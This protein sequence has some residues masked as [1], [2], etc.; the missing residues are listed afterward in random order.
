MAETHPES[1]SMKP[2]LNQSKN[3]RES[4]R[5]GSVKEQDRKEADN[6]DALMQAQNGG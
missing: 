1:R 5:N 2:K 3:Q 4:N 6:D